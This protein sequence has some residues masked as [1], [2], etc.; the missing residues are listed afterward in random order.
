MAEEDAVGQPDA[1]TFAPAMAAY[2]RRGWKLIERPF[3]RKAARYQHV[4]ARI[5]DEWAGMGDV[6]RRSGNGGGGACAVSLTNEPG[7]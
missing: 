5:A 1:R 4:P 6:R 7:L 3:A 2:P